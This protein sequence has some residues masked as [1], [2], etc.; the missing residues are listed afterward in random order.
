M[1]TKLERGNIFEKRSG[2]HIFFAVNKEGYNDAGFAGLVSSQYWPE[3]SNTGGNELGE[4]LH[5][6]Y[7]K[8]E[9]DLSGI[10][11][12]ACVCHSLEDGWFAAPAYVIKCLGELPD[13]LISAVLMGNGFVG[14]MQGADVEQIKAA[15]R[16]SNRKVEVFYL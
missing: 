13:E 8:D 4:C 16:L 10:H 2:N 5:F 11:F 14:K 3:L 12:H 1:I 9:N 6:H 15:F 7:R